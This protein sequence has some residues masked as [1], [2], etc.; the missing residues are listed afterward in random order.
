MLEKV[1]VTGEP[2]G[3]DRKVCRPA[4]DVVEEVGGEDGQHE[5]LHLVRRPV[6]TEVGGHLEST[7]KWNLKLV[8]VH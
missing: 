1:L 3:R 2:V 7:V 6:G 8:E 4:D 5:R